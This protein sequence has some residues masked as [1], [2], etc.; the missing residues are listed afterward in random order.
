MT[1]TAIR[2]MAR[3]MYEATPRNKP[4]PIE[5]QD[6]ARRCK[7]EARARAALRALRDV[8]PSGEVVLA[9]DAAHYLPQPAPDPTRLPRIKAA[10]RAAIGAMIEEDGN[11]VG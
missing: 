9:A 2:A 4:W 11:N 7:W 6:A 8:E 1:S 3:G 5:A 10:I